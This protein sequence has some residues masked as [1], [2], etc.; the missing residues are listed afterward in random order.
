MGQ[1]NMTNAAAEYFTADELVTRWKNRVTVGTLAN[2]RA[3]KNRHRSPPFVK[4]GRNVLYPV[5][6]V[7]EW[8]AK[9]LHAANDNQP[10]N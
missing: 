4:F 2:W 5:A 8:E 3:K 9:N 7:L 1:G 6:G 10:P